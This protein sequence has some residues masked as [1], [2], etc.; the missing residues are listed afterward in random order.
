M[1][2][3]IHF[4]F[5]GKWSY[6]MGI[7]QAGVNS[8]LYEDPILSSKNI[9]EE[10]IEGRERP[11]FFGVDREP[12][13]LNISITFQENLTDEK[14]REIMRWLDKDEY[15]PLRMY[16]H[17]E[18]LWY[19][20]IVN[21]V[22]S[23]HNG[24]N[25]GY[26]ELELRASHSTAL[27]PLAVSETYRIRSNVW[28]DITFENNGDFDCYPIVHINK[29]GNGNI[30]IENLTNNTG[31]FK[32]EQLEDGELLTIFCETKEIES[33]TGKFRYDNFSK[34]HLVFRRG[35]NRLRVRGNFNLTFETEFKIY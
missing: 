28:K 22:R 24:I 13:T 21:D 1:R 33:S 15:K 30:E 17:P 11:Y 34:N 23:I 29:Y 8:G 10:R 18:K 6:E 16:E 26:I 9:I 7:I 3:S 4:N 19:V 14:M 12:L 2:E 5:D 31:V 27:S 20:M 35:I 25:S 32:F